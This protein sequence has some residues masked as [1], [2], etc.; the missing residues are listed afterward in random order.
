MTTLDRR[1][2]FKLATAAGAMVAIG[3]LDTASRLIPPSPGQTITLDEFHTH[4]FRQLSKLLCAAL[5]GQRD[6]MD[7]AY[8]AIA[9]TAA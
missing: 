2:F 5:D 7:R 3:P 8:D 1:D 9:R 6:A 4:L